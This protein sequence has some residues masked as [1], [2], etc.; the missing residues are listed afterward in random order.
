[1]CGLGS[2]SQPSMTTHIERQQ[3]KKQANST[4]TI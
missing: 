4:D 2:G 3:T 1:M